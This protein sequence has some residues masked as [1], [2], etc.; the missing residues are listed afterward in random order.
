MTGKKYKDIFIRQKNSIE[1]VKEV[2][3][4]DTVGI[5]N[6]HESLEMKT[7]DQYKFVIEVVNG[8]YER[9]FYQVQNRDQFFRLI[10]NNEVKNKIIRDDTG[11]KR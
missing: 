9:R 11:G 2:I 3:S 4:G 10:M 6:A 5:W 7:G 8:G 1:Q